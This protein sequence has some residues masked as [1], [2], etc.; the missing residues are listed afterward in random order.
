MDIFE[1]QTKMATIVRSNFNLLPVINRFGISLGFKDKTV[2]Q[3][4]NEEKINTEFFLAIRTGLVNIPIGY[5]VTTFF[6]FALGLNLTAKRF[7]LPNQF[8]LVGFLLFFCLA[9]DS[10][11]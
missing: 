9:E 1:E 11:Y 4:C 8:Q 7:A 6:R 10:R 2:V 5:D 3:I